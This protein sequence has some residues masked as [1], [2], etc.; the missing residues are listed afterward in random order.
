MATVDFSMTVT[1]ATSFRVGIIHLHRLLRILTL[2]QFA[3]L[4]CQVRIISPRDFAKTMTY[5]ILTLYVLL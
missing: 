3:C 5:P 1:V 2:R 4:L